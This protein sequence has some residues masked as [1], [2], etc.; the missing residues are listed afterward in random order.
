[1]VEARSNAVSDFRKCGTDCAAKSSVERSSQ[2]GEAMPAAKTSRKKASARSSNGERP[3][4]PDQYLALDNKAATKKMPSDLAE[5]AATRRVE[6]YSPGKD[7]DP[8]EIIRQHNTS[9]TWELN[10]PPGAGVGLPGRKSGRMSPAEIVR[11]IKG[12]ASSSSLGEPFKPEWIDYTPHPKLSTASQPLMRRVN[13]RWYEPHF[14]VFGA[15]DRQIYYPSGY[16]W[17]CIGRI[18]VWDDFSKPSP[19]WLGSGVLI[20]G[21]VVLT[22][23]HIAPWGSK[24]WAMQFIPAFYDGTSTLGPGATSWVSDY[25]G[26]NTN[27]QESAWDMVVLRLYT[28]LG[29]TYGYFGAKTYDSDWEGGNYWTLAGYP[30][31][32][33]NTNRPARQMWW[34][35]LDDDSDGNADELEYEADATPGDSGGP[36]FGFWTR[37]PYAIAT[38]SGGAKSTF[39]WWT[40]ED[41]N[42]GCGG[43][44]LP[45]LVAWARSNWP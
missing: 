7:F 39:L 41:N 4:T 1:M 5:A 42:I 43:S 3:F 38:H 20:G 13:G 21:R 40:V 23:G 31:A 35:V 25:W 36:V 18:A 10:L 34:P 8:R 27:Q 37:G 9:G 12:N 15:E 17:T 45:S 32:V 28:P 44:A 30:A 26:Y 2:K 29:N 22:A 6:I 19:A 16:P 14:G 33:G 24:N 11:G